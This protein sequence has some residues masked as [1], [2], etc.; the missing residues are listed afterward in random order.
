MNDELRCEIVR[1]QLQSAHTCIAEGL[2]LQT[3]GYY[4]AAMARLYYAC[5]HAASALLIANGMETKTHNG[6]RTILGREFVQTGKFSPELGR[7]Y[8]KMYNKRQDGDYDS[9]I[10]FEDKDVEEVLPYV[11]QF[12]E[13]VKKNIR[14]K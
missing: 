5:F 1:H 7:F 2:Y 6:V 14:I 3:G 11:K 13:E 9:F 4:N 8:T 12:V 10:F